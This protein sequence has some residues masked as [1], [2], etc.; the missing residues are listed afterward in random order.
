MASLLYRAVSTAGRTVVQNGQRVL[1]VC[2]N[3]QQR[4]NLSLHEYHSLQLLRDAGVV[5]PRGEVARSPEEAFEIAKKLGGEDVVIKAQV[6][7]GGRGKGSFDS[8]LKGG[9]KIVFSPEECKDIATKMLGHK[10]FTK[11]TGEA[12]RICNEVLLVE[13]LYPRRE[14]YF[15]IVMERA[16][17]GPAIVASSQGG[18]NIEEIAEEY[19][20]AI[21]KEGIDIVEGLSIDQARGI[22]AKMNFQKDLQ[23]EAAEMMVKIYEMFSRTDATMV[24]INPMSEDSNGKVYCM[25][26]KVRFDDN[27][28]YRQKDIFALRDWSQEDERDIQAAKA[29]LNY[30]G[31]DGNIGC[32]VNGAGLAM[33]TMDI[34]KLHGG[35]PAN[36]LDVGGGATA[37]QVTEAFKLITSDPNVQAIMV[38]IFGGIMRCDVI[39]QGII[40][41]ATEL[42]LKVPIVVRL[43]GTQVD[44]AKALIAA[45]GLRILACDNLD[46]AAKMAVRL[47]TIV[48]LAKQTKVDVKFE[49]PTF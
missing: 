10:I 46:D 30:I 39:A 28:E 47:S 1:G 18:V 16:Y 23:E 11:Q 40:E 25:D 17:G 49:L 43:Q 42:D 36:F 6:L 26:A 14:F 37:A 4:R 20:D 9:V 12:G 15:A 8:G 32:L 13:R 22:A 3:V 19:P 29:D 21:I 27:A 48:Q 34:I 33:A 31:L 45:S 7:A 5:T 38:N 35:S 2:P 44:D 24:E 41:A